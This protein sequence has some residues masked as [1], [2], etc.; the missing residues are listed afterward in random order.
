M[1]GVQIGTRLSNRGM[2]KL[3]SSLNQ[4]TPLRIV[5]KNFREKFDSFR[6]S[7]SEHFETKAIRDSTKNDDQHPSQLLV[8]CPDVGSLANHVIKV[9]N[10]SGD[11]LIKIG[12][13]GGGGFLKVSLGIIARNTDSNSPPP[14][15]GLKATGVK[16]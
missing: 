10:V 7:L 16:R 12:I 5:E 2:S 14:K 15:R 3:A 13:D 1:V 11:P 8:F 9:M 4:A 6:K